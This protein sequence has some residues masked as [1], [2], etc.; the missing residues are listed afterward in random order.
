MILLHPLQLL[1]AQAGLAAKSPKSCIT[2]YREYGGGKNSQ[3]AN[4]AH[5]TMKSVLPSKTV[6]VTNSDYENPIV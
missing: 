6:V 4:I 2:H 5:L 3:E 1:G